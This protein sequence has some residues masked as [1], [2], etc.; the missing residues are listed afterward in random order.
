MRVLHFVMRWAS[1]CLNERW[2]GKYWMRSSR[3]VTSNREPHQ[4]EGQRQSHAEESQ[5]HDH[6]GIGGGVGAQCSTYRYNTSLSTRNR[7]FLL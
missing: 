3:S 6:G 5:R 2:K 7:L 4:Q 1:K